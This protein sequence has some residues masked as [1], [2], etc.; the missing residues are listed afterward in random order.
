[1]KHTMS[2]WFSRLSPQK[3]RIAATATA[4]GLAAILPGCLE[5]PLGTAAPRTTNIIVDLLPQNVVDKVDMLFVIDNSM[6]MAD[7]QAI[8]AEAVPDL[9]SRFV[10][11]VC[12]NAQNQ[13]A[14][15]GANGECPAG[16]GPEFTP[17]KDI[18][19]GVI[20]SSLG[21]FGSKNDCVPDGDP[22]VHPYYV[23]KYDMAHLMGSLA[24]DASVP[25]SSAVRR[26]AQVAAGGEFLTWSGGDNAAL[27]TLATN[28]Q[29]QVKGAG[30]QGCGWEA[31]MEAWVHFLVDPEPFTSIV[32]QNCNA[33]DTK[34]S[35]AGPAPTGPD[36]TILN[37]RKAFLRM[38][39]LL[40]VIMLTDEND[41][42]F[43]L[44]GQQWLVSDTA[45]GSN[46]GTFRGSA[47]CANDPNDPCCQSCG[48]PASGSCPGTTITLAGN[49]FNAPSGCET[50][51]TYPLSI[52]GLAEG[53]EDQGN[54]RCFKQKMRFGADFLLPVER[55]ANALNEIQICPSNENLSPTNCKGA[56][57]ENPVF[58]RDGETRPKTLVFFGGIVGVPWQDLAIDPAAPVLKYRKAKSDEAN[59]EI[60]WDL[61]L[62]ARVNG[63]RQLYPANDGTID[64][65][66]F[67][68]VDVRT[69]PGIQPPTA[70]FMANPSNGHE[71][72]IVDRS[73]LQ[74]ACI[75]PKAPT[76]CPTQTEVDDADR[77]DPTT[78]NPNC[79]CTYY[80]PGLGDGA[81][82]NSPLCQQPNGDYGLT[83]SFGKAYPGIRELQALELFAE[84]NP[85]KNAIV[86]S[87]CPKEAG[88]SPADKQKPDWGYRP[89]VATIV[90]RLKEQLQEPCLPR[91]LAT[92]DDG[93]AACIIVEATTSPEGCMIGEATARGPVS[94]S[95]KPLV[96]QALQTKELCTGEQCKDYKLCEVPQIKPTDNGYVSC[97]TGGSDSNGWCYLDRDKLPTGV[98][99]AQ[100]DGILAKCP[101]TSK[102]KLRF[103]GLGKAQTASSLTF[104]ACSGSV[105]DVE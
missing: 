103:S 48:K 36:Q 61:L 21:G 83:Q 23:Q 28:F 12:L 39:S 43:K 58:V 85:T 32:R 2:Q 89:A 105:Y 6:S 8:M 50:E 100:V 49:P 69:G 47:Q 77:A 92:K 59:E 57:V 102:R 13:E 71:W 67:E 64:P 70:G 11:P 91:P 25:D 60:N 95:I 29:N 17:I 22:P 30:E 80:G 19:I 54:L 14:A 7:K 26:N 41:C 3:N 46:T 24:E 40:A 34:E 86:A 51:Q 38:D 94:E 5:R 72:N 35:C 65:L 74:Y 20:T 93:G 27:Q 16:Y 99:E 55:Y 82:Y 90:D 75:F 98:D 44:S 31:S 88:D 62:G 4:V 79:D 42:S 76:N 10:K 45:G 96:Y 15:Y 66:M 104:F 101:D 37:Q 78:P 53:S 56:V 33:S 1:M 68:S 9:V 97:I 18:H 87:I 84:K 63:A 81:E 52:L 73:D